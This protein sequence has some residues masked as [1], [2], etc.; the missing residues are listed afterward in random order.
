MDNGSNER[1]IPAPKPTDRPTYTVLVDGE[2]LPRQ[3]HVIS[4]VVTKAVNRI[5]R[6]K[7][8]LKDGD[9]AEEDFK[10][11]NTG[12]FIPGAR[13]EI[14]AGYHSDESKIFSGI[15]MKHAIRVRQGKPSTLTVECM[16]EAVRMSVSRRSAYY[17]DSSDSEVFETIAGMYSIGSDIEE[18]GVEHKELVQYCSTD[19]DFIVSRA[20]ANGMLVLTNDE[21]LR[22]KRPD[23]TA[24][25]AV[26][27]LYG[28]TI[29]EFDAELD[30]R[31]QVP[32]VEG[33]SWDMANQEVL[34]AEGEEP[35]MAQQGNL[36]PEE[37]ADAVGIIEDFSVRH[38]G[39]L[40]DDELKTWADARLLR[41]RLSKI[42]GRARFTGFGEIEPGELVELSGVGERFSGRA[43][44]S[45]VRHEL[46]SGM[47]TTDAQFGLSPSWFTEEKKVNPEPASGLLPAVNGL[48]IGVVTR[49]QDDPDGEDRVLVRMPLVSNDDDGVW[50]RVAAL[51]AGDGRGSFFRPEIGDEVV[52]GF[53]NDDPRDPVILGMLN[54]SA[55]PA[56][57][58][59]SDDNHEKGFVTRSGI[60]LIFDDGKK[61]ITIE[62]PGGKRF[63]MDDD[64]GET[65]IEDENS[66]RFKMDSSG[67]TIESPA[68]IKIKA[69]GDIKV[70]GTNVATEAAA[71]FKAKGASG[72]EMS[73]SA[74]A[75][76]KG[77][78][79]QIN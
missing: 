51:D 66:N 16:H 73:T 8:I 5:S 21:K 38:A 1:T 44:V 11:S 10:V 78:L 22:V 17:H 15:V 2:E 57:I 4:I 34:K 9:P 64:T 26:S 3:Y 23:F 37:L 7:I 39:S 70:E 71:Q 19:W 60:R 72:A 77:A 47:W 28:A 18:T 35:E 55:K 74:T 29:V 43:F 41:S 69:G 79:V 75:V 25:P 67:I 48:Q 31:T 27:L 50:A 6:A 14:L 65:T 53:L 58:T 45:A 42:Q 30:A 49:L 13:I 40:P 54:S 61:S 32:S 56:P 20:E 59:A 46:G 36:D 76:I 68:D 63:T 62:T 12:L 52:L 33:V 24:E